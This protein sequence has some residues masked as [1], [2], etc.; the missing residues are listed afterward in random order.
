[1]PRNALLAIMFISS[2]SFGLSAA[3]AED[4]ATDDNYT[5]TLNNNVFTPAELTVPAGQKIKLKVKN[6]QSNNAEFESEDLGR[7]KLVGPDKEITVLVGPLAAGKYM[8]VNDFH[9]ESTGIIIAK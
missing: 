6:L 8:Y 7:E 5:I 9:R 4:A 3:Y 2:V 1:M